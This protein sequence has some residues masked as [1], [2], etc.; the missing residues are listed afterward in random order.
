MGPMSPLARRAVALL[1]IVLLIAGVAV[2]TLRGM[3]A[4][5]ALGPLASSSPA[6]AQT[7]MPTGG[8]VSPGATPDADPVTVFAGIEDEVRAIRLLPAPDIG[9]AELIGHDALVAELKASFDRDYPQA[10]RDADN[11]VLRA[12][13]LLTT[14]QDVAALQLQLLSDQVIGFYDDTQRRMVVVSDAGVDALAR[15]TYAHEYTHALQDGAFGLDALDT[16]AVGEDD[17]DLARLGLVEGDASLAMVLW[18]IANDPA[19]LAEVAGTPVPD[20]SGIPDWMVA[21]L[22]FPYAAGANFVSGLYQNGGFDA[23]DAAYADPP[24]STEQVLHPTKYTA[25]EAPIEVSEV[26]LAP[27]LGAGWTDVPSTTIG[28]AMIAIWLHALG[29]DQADADD[30]AAG[31]G[32]DRASVAT[33]GSDV[34]L[35]WRIAFDASAQADD[36]ERTYGDLVGSLP[37]P[38]RFERTSAT[39]VL[40][41][42]ASDAGLLDAIAA[43]GE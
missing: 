32:G 16:D 1:V 6:T 15:I 9:P 38:G 10:R 27:A 21:Q 31:W 18:A 42:Q 30:A 39:E 28:E 8:A 13:G 24:D 34:A 14:D 22:S 12:L 35:A 41:L 37:L 17:R 43:A 7:P 40:V 20:M 36:F 11:A 4:Q 25:G 3:G 26:A 33:D 29:A 5:I 23:V 19:G 2:L